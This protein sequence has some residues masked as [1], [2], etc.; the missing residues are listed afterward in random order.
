[1]TDLRNV[2]KYLVCIVL[3]VGLAA[4]AGTRTKESTGEYVD[5]S[6]ITSK[7]KG[8]LIADP[9]TKAREIN[10]ETF[11]GTV[12]LSGFVGTAEEKK[13]AGEIAR[14]VKGVVEVRNNISLTRTKEGTGE[15]VDDKVITSKVKAALIADPVTKA[16][17][18]NVETS[19]GTVQL[20]GFVSTAEEKNKA[21]EIAR[22]VK[23]VVN[24]QNN[25]IVK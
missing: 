24:V 25:I 13:K 19:K 11:K 21:G 10:V 23:G 8:A 2:M 16:R 14:G 22:D 20:S 15:Y 3:I 18:I 6:V 1:M 9:V 12:Q 5:D 4:C 17:E 7:V